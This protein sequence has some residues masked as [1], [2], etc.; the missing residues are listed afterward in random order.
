MTCKYCDRRTGPEI[1]RLKLY[2]QRAEFNRRKCMRMAFVSM[3]L[4]INKSEKDEV[5]TG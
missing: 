3:T 5:G 2:L 4:R 1:L